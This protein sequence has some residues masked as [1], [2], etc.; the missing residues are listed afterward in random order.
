MTV[1]A[2]QALARI[3]RPNRKV[4]DQDRCDHGTGIL[5]HDFLDRCTRGIAPNELRVIGSS[6]DLATGY[7][8]Q[9]LTEVE[10]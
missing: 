6:P 8:L 7:R 2:S 5:D 1:S 10:L 4:G 9:R 3:V